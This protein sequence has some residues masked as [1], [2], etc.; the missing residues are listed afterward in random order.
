MK[1]KAI[2]TVATAD[3]ARDLAIEWQNWQSEQSLSL[4]QTLEWQAY[5]EKL[6]NKFP[7][8]TEEFKENCII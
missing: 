6:A 3:E 8:L 2:E 1:E 5:F 4:D 7:D